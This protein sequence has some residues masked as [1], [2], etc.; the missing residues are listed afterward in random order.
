ML[1]HIRPLHSLLALL[2]VFFLGLFFFVQ[3]G[4]SEAECFSELVC[5]EAGLLHP[6]QKNR[7]TEYHQALLTQ[8]DI[9]Y[10]VGS[11]NL[12]AENI[13]KIFKTAAIGEKSKTRKGLLLMIDPQKN[14]VRLEVSAGL[15][16][17]YTDGF[18]AYIQQRQM[19]PF[20]QANRVADGIMA[21][22]EMIVTRAQEA[23]KGNAFTPPS[24]LPQNLSI[25]AGA[26]TK[27][28]IGTGYVRPE[29][30]SQTSESPSGLSPEQVVEAYHTALANGNTSPDLAI[31][32]RATQ[33]LKKQ[34]VV[35]KG[36]MANE[37]STYKQCTVDKAV[38]LGTK[39]RAVVRYKVDDRKC[40]PY[41]LV[42]ENGAWRLDFS[43]MMQSLRFNVS[44]DWHFDMRSP[45][46]YAEAFQDWSLDA[47]GYPFAQPKMRW[48]MTVSTDYNQGVTWIS[49][50]Y[51][52]TPVASMPLKE[53]D[54]ILKWDSLERFDH[55][56]IFHSM[57]ELETGK[58][59]QV[60]IWR[61]GK[62]LKL[63]LVVPPEV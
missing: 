61:D 44:N 25:G 43:T 57:G 56:D 50:I 23:E 13:A 20:F 36:Q 15:D 24:Q 33:E 54:V 60:E 4:T 7:L 27:A 1:M 14:L 59:I 53:M 22:T 10:R 21:T 42:M 52:G 49:K 35:T 34:W 55:R 37:L 16:A 40:A 19:V 48:G 17:V 39:D 12:S 41:F 2:L 45:I 30:T 47:N 26:Q 5:D 8:Y 51:P 28:S 18:V 9:D 31:Y 32:S 58:T 3:K 11:G 46:P 29:T 6:E 63:N 62:Q 38:I